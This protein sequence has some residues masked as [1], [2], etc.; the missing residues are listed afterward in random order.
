MV[1]SQLYWSYVCTGLYPY[2]ISATSVN[3]VQCYRNQRKLKVEWYW[4]I[5]WSNIRLSFYR[6][7]QMLFWSTWTII[8]CPEYIEHQHEPYLQRRV[9]FFIRND[10]ILAEFNYILFCRINDVCV[11]ISIRTLTVMNSVKR[12]HFNQKITLHCKYDSYLHKTNTIVFISISAVE[13]VQPHLSCTSINRTS[14]FGYFIY[15]SA[16]THCQKCMSVEE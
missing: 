3:S 5:V 13:L 2:H 1:W 6:I 8:L 12:Y 16:G 14:F 4:M 11:V 15:S 9:I 10:T 7:C